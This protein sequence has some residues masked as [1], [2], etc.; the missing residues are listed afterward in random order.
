MKKKEFKIRAKIV[1]NGNFLIQAKSK[2]EAVGK[3][4]Q[5]CGAMLGNI[6]T[7]DYYEK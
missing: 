2:E 6:Q 4:K 7:L 1:F 5:N 3:F